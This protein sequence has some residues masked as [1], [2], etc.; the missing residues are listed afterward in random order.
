MKT[1]FLTGLVFVLSH[2]GGLGQD[3]LAFNKV[4]FFEARGDGEEKRD[5]RLELDATNKILRVVDEKNGASKAMYLEVPYGSITKIVYE[6][7]AHRR[8]KAGILVSP[9]L[10][11]TKGKKHWLT[12]EFRDVAKHP[13]GFASA[14]L[15]KDNYRRILTALSAAT[16]L[17]IQE[18]IED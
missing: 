9:W 12:I 2:G 17:E 11:L 5:A 4:D 6:R 8:Y 14:Q 15:D 13:A 18:M 1:I 7:S 16:S 3:Q 10:L